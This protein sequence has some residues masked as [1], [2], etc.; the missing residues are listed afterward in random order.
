ML[1]GFETGASG[2]RKHVPGTDMC[3]GLTIVLLPQCLI[4]DI[5]PGLGRLME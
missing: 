1:G 2:W 3:V 5:L 4:N